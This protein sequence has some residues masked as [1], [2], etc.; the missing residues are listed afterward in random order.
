MTEMN[1]QALVPVIQGL[2][3]GGLCQGCGQPLLGEGDIQVDY[4]EPPRHPRDWTRLHTQNL[5]WFCSACCSR[6][7][8]KSFG[9]WRD[10][11]WAAS[12]ARRKN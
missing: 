1:Y 8:G 9:Q 10:D 4:I 6:R 2:M 5:V 7:T 12:E 3:N 11:E